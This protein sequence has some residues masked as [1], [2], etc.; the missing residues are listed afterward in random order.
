MD[1]GEDNVFNKNDELQN[2]AFKKQSNVN[3]LDIMGD[4]AEDL[5]ENWEE[6]VDGEGV[7]EGSI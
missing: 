7:I 2:V 6:A 4:L 5:D 3:D 1:L